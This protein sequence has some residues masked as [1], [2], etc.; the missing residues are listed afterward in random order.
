MELT[1]RSMDYMYGGAKI[2]IE[3]VVLK[4]LHN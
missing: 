4:R 3:T 1:E 2:N